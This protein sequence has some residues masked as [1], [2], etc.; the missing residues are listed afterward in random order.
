MS[1]SI[2]Q[3]VWWMDEWS[4]C[5]PWPHYV[6]QCRPT[7]WKPITSSPAVMRSCFSSVSRNRAKRLSRTLSNPRAPARMWREALES[8]SACMKITKDAHRQISVMEIILSSTTDPMRQPATC[9]ICQFKS[10]MMFCL[11]WGRLSHTPLSSEQKLRLE[12][13]FWKVMSNYWQRFKFETWPASCLLL[14][15]VLMSCYWH[16][17]YEYK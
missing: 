1:V 10:S 13:D 11:I 16:L 12:I 8:R 6:P 5:S 7:A 3:L 15:L 2:S 17:F 14:F 4:K 9:Q